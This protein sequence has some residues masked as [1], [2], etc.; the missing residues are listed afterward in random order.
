MA[1][2]LEGTRLV[3]AHATRSC[4]V[5][6]CFRFRTSEIVPVDLNAIICGNLLLMGDLYD[7]VGDIDGSKWCAQSADLM[8]QTIYQVGGAYS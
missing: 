3:L 6:N 4:L 1:G 2:K 7:A 8:K 5:K